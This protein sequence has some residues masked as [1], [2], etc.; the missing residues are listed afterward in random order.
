MRRVWSRHPPTPAAA[1]G[2]YYKQNSLTGTPEEEN[3]VW[4]AHE[5]SQSLKRLHKFN[6]TGQEWS[7]WEELAFNGDRTNEKPRAHLRLEQREDRRK[8]KE[9]S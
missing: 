2:L 6:R 9:N 1:H 7:A 8:N 4:E 5:A 3:A